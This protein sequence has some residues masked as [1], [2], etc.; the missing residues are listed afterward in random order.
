[1]ATEI[2]EFFGYR[3]TDRTPEAVESAER[4][5]CPFIDG[6]CT[7][8]LSDGLIAGVCSLKPSRSTPVICCPNRLYAE[9]YQALKDVAGIAFGQGLPMAIGRRAAELARAEGSDAIAIFGKGSG[10]ELRLPQRGGRGGYFV[11]WILAR[12]NGGGQLLDFVAVEVQSIDTTGNYRPGR[13]ALLEPE[14]LVVRNTAGFNWENVNKR[15]I[16]QLLYKGNVLQRES[17]CTKGLF[18]I[19]PQAVYDRIMNR[20]GGPDVLLRY[21]L[22]SSSITF[23]PYDYAGGEVTYG[24]R[25]PLEL[26]EV[27]TTNI[28]QMAQAFAGPGVMPPENSYRDAIRLALQA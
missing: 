28:G 10:G 21:P 1:M 4:R 12:V 3:A 19:S 2:F 17:L 25:L 5:H 20:L 6:Q 16:P 22:Q 7:K 18:F 27:F 13:N 8:V 24:E 11:D 9:E 23:M 26:G 15:I 14:R